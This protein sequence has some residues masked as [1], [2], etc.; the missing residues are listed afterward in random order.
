M[1]CILAPEIN[2]CV[3]CSLRVLGPEAQTPPLHYSLK[4]LHAASGLLVSSQ[5]SPQAAVT[6]L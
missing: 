3:I 6:P 5:C 1:I 2:G 4:E